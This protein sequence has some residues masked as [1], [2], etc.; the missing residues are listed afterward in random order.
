MFQRK[1]SILSCAVQTRQIKIP[2]CTRVKYDRVTSDSARTNF[3]EV[4]VLN[5]RYIVKYA[6]NQYYLGN[7]FLFSL[8]LNVIK[9]RK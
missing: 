1:Y 7:S 3:S 2:Y 9:T 6:D 4:P 8:L 5:L